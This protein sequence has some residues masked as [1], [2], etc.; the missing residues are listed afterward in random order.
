[1]DVAGDER[2]A[3]TVTQTADHQPMAAQQSLRAAWDDLIADLVRARDAVD[4]PACYAPPGDDRLLAEGYRY[5]LGFLYGGIER[6]LMDPRFT[7]LRRAIQPMD[8]ATID[9]A[10][11]MYL[12]APIDGSQAYVITGKAQDFRHW[13]GEEPAPTGRKAPQYVIVEVMKG[14]AGDTGKLDE[15]FSGARAGTGSLDVSKLHVEEDGTFEILL[16]PERP[17]G[18]NGNF[19]PTYRPAE[20]VREEA[21]A[22]HVVL[23]ELFHDWEREDNLELQIVRVGADSEHPLPLDPERAAVQM[24][25]LGEIV[26]NQMLFWNEFYTVLLET[27][28]DMNGDGKRFMPRNEFNEPMLSTMAIGGGQS[29]NV[30]AGCTYEL[31]P[32]EAM[33]IENRVPVKPAFQGIHLSNLWGESHDYANHQSSLN[34]FQSEWDADGAVRWVVAHRD[35]GVPNWLETTG[36]PVGYISPRWSYSE[37]PSEL[38]TISARIVR[39]DEIR[40]HLPPETR[41]IAAEERRERIRIR[42][43]HVQRRYRQY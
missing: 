25:R 28:A 31:G 24:R 33:I 20:G 7:Y 15:L 29:T 16:A 37:P 35:P 40:S 21:V 4:D 39:F 3:G 1:M 43:E 11:A 18:H 13:R 9:N 30:Y 27:H 14:Y 32:D 26:R 10:D 6:A 12:V 41:S 36:I 19:I 42:Q 2:K 23:R 34:A 38:P 17:E 5:L 22:N 8:K